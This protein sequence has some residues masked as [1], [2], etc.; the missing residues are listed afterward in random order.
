MVVRRLP[1]PPPEGKTMEV[2]SHA[3]SFSANILVF[4]CRLRLS[5]HRLPVVQEIHAL[6]WVQPFSPVSC[7]LPPGDGLK[8][9]MKMKAV[10]GWYHII[11]SIP[12]SVGAARL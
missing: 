8:K 4:P 3:N 9:W 5:P 2:I 6:G 12:S 7:L 1:V 11:G 10:T